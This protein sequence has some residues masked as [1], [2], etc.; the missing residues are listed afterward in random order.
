M[1]FSYYQPVRLLQ[2][3]QYKTL[4]MNDWLNNIFTVVQGPESLTSRKMVEDDNTTAD[5]NNRKKSVSP[6]IFQKL[7][8]DAFTTAITAKFSFSMEK[9]L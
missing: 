5:G 7:K 3:I 4:V 6:H 1:H 8:G 2:R 9:P